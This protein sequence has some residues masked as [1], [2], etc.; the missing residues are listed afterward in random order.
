MPTV[1]ITVVLKS[2]ASLEGFKDTSLQDQDA[3]SGAS[4]GGP[5]VHKC[6]TKKRGATDW[7]LICAY[8]IPYMLCDS[9]KSA[10]LSERNCSPLR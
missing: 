7:S 9:I 1:L 3:S 2:G 10:G 5:P 4:S 6:C 8:I